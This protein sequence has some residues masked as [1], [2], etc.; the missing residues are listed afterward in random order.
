MT[1]SKMAFG[2][3]MLSKKTQKHVAQPN[4]GHLNDSWQYDNWQN[5]NEPNKMTI[6]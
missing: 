3:M 2:R 1:N 6:K 4:N 5:D